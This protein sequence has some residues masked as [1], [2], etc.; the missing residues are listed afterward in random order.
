MISRCT[1]KS[2]EDYRRLF[3]LFLHDLLAAL[4]K[5]EWPAA[6]MMLFILGNLLVTFYRSKTIDMSL[7]IAR[8]VLLVLQFWNKLFLCFSKTLYAFGKNLIRHYVVKFV[9]VVWTTWVQ[10]RRA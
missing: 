3:D 1:A 10:S 9:V 5:P 7:R 6:E 2:E 8:F 4:Y